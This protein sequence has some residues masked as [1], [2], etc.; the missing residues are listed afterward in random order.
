MIGEPCN[1]INH[2]TDGDC[3][4]DGQVGN[5]CNCDGDLYDCAGICGGDTVFDDCGV[6]G[7]TCLNPA[8]P[9]LSQPDGCFDCGCLNI[10][11]HCLSTG[12]PTLAGEVADPLVIINGGPEIVGVYG[13]CYC[14]V[15]DN[16]GVVGGNNSSFPNGEPCGGCPNEEA[17]NTNCNAIVENEELCIFPLDNT[18]IF[19][20]LLPTYAEPPPTGGFY[21]IDDTNYVIFNQSIENGQYIN[22]EEF[23]NNYYDNNFNNLFNAQLITLLEDNPDGVEINVDDGD[24]DFHIFYWQSGAQYGENGG[25]QINYPNIYIKGGVNVN[26]VGYVGVDE[27]DFITIATNSFYTVEGLENYQEGFSTLDEALEVYPDLSPQDICGEFGCWENT[28]TISVNYN[29]DEEQLVNLTNIFNSVDL[30]FL[31]IN[32]WTV[33]F[34]TFKTARGYNI[35]TTKSGFIKWS[36]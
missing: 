6:C 14:E 36:E 24:P 17:L 35:R 1:P 18:T 22:T 4:F 23:L 3:T 16:C 32:E 7:G 11:Q 12:L 31:I 9:G 19:N 26:L 8:E 30:G 2:L 25:Q 10:E 29:D 13:N 33:D 15:I 34:Q 28:D 21:L 27:S 5:I 20:T